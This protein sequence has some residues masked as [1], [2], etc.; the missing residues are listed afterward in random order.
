MGKKKQQEK[1]QSNPNPPI[2]DRYQHVLS[3]IVAIITLAATIVLAVSASIIAFRA[4]R[5]ASAGNDIA[6]L[7]S[8]VLFTTHVSVSEPGDFGYIAVNNFEELDISIEWVDFVEV[9]ILSGSVRSMGVIVPNIDN[10]LR[11]IPMPD[12]KFAAN[13]GLLTQEQSII[14]TINEPL[15]FTPN[16]YF[17]YSFI[18]AIAGDGTI[19][20]VMKI[21]TNKNGN[22]TPHPD[23]FNNVMLVGGSSWVYD[24]EENPTQRMHDDAQFVT[25]RFRNVHRMLDEYR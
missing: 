2:W 1:K 10:S 24:V 15:V 16:R 13:E 3:I 23:V 19:V 5:V 8:P 4:N 20:T 17:A 25:D 21:Y 6:V 18:Y 14:I 12:E 9:T 7:Q 22:I 11:V